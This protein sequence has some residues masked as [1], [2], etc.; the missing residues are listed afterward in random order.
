MLMCVRIVCACVGAYIHENMCLLVS[1]HVCTCARMFMYVRVCARVRVRVR[2]RVH[3]RV[4]QGGKA[5]A[6]SACRDYV[7]GRL[8]GPLRAEH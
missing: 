3:A 7:C 2:M 8:R 4:C 5:R 6:A 1:V